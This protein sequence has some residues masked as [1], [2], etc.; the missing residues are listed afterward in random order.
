MAPSIRAFPNPFSITSVQQPQTIQF[1]SNPAEIAYVCSTFPYLC[2]A[3]AVGTSYAPV[4][5]ASSGLAVTFSIDAASTTGAC[6]I[7]GGTVSFT[8]PGTCIIDANQ[9]G[10]S[11]YAPAPQVQQTVP[12]VDNDLTLTSAP[13]NIVVDA[14]DP[15]GAIVIYPSPVVGDADDGSLPTLSCIAASGTT[16]AIGTTTVVCTVADAEDTDSPLTA[17]FTVTVK[18]APTQLLDLSAQVRGVG[19]GESLGVKLAAARSALAN[20]DRQENP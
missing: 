9:A 10:G 2:M 12:V 7:S 18:G 17:T 4:A 11:G 6:S 13:G 5:T 14:T 8:G 1:T 3:A 15:A 16:F 19:P 20:G